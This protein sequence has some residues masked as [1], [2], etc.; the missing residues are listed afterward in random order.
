MA[1]PNPS[2]SRS[3]DT[4]LSTDTANAFT[5]HGEDVLREI[6]DF[7]SFYKNLGGQWSRNLNLPDSGPIG[8]IPLILTTEEMASQGRYI[9]F[10]AGADSVAWNFKLRGTVQET[11]TGTI[12]HYFK[13]SKRNTFFDEPEAQFQFQSGNIMAARFTKNPSARNPPSGPQA[14]TLVQLPLGLMNFYEF[15]EILDQR[16]VLSDGRTNFVY[17]M[18]SSMTFPRMILRGFFMPEQGVSFTENADGGAEIKWSATFKVV[19]TYPKFQ[20]A[21]SLASTWRE[22]QEARGFET[23]YDTSAFTLNPSDKTQ[24]GM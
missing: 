10:W 8:R 1:G 17:I 21:Q 20:S 11:R 13:D 18:Y 3:P 2:G 23:L 6:D 16:K 5:F 15:M 4:T 14:N 7:S 9:V 19:S 22:L 12:Q 24:A